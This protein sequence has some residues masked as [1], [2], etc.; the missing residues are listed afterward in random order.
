M[1][2]IF[3]MIRNQDNTALTSIDAIAF[4]TLLRQN[5]QLLAEEIVDLVYADA[6]FDDLPLGHYTVGVRH[7]SVEPQE[8]TCAVTIDAEDEVILLTF[9]YLEPER[10]LLGIRASTEKRL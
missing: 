6:G 8:A 4:M 7:E 1:S 10:V 2:D 5:S 3:V 9:V